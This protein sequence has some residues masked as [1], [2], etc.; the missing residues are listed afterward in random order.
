MFSR[1]F[2][3]G[4]FVRIRVCSGRRE[5]IQGLGTAS[6]VYAQRK[7]GLKDNAIPTIGIRARFKIVG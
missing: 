5:S 3:A 1:E 4:D 6:Y 7:A 2:L